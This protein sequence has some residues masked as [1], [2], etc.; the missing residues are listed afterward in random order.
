MNILLGVTGSIA[1]Y[2]A[3]DI[4]R[5]WVKEGHQVKVVLTQSATSF[6]HTSM[7]RHLGAKDVYEFHQDFTTKNNEILH[8]ELAR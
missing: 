8:I 7:F 1:A 2:K 6:C 4:C 3:Y 5:Y